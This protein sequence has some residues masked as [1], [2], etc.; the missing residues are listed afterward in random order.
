MTAQRETRED[1]AS[2]EVGVTDVAPGIARALVVFFLVL[3]FLVPSAQ[4]LVEW[5]RGGL[6]SLSGLSLWDP[7]GRL[8]RVNDAEPGAERRREWRRV[9]AG[10]QDEMKAYETG[11]EES[12]VLREPVIDGMRGVFTGLLGVGT[13]DAYMGRDGWLFYRPGID[14]LTGDPFL[15]EER[16]ARIAR[17][18]SEFKAPRAA[19]PVAAL[20]DFA[21]ALKARDIQLVVVPAPGKAQIYPEYF[22]GR[23]TAADAGL[24]N[25]SFGPFAAR[26]EEAGVVVVDLVAEF[27][28]MRAA[29]PEAALY[30]RTDTHWTPFG[31][32]LAANVV[33]G[34][35]L[36]GVSGFA[37][38]EFHSDVGRARLTYQGDVASMLQGAAGL[39]EHYLKTVHVEP[40]QNEA[41]SGD[42]DILVLDDSF[43]N[44]YS[45]PVM[46]WGENAGFVEHLALALCRPMDAITIN[47]N[48][49]H[50]ARVALE[51]D[52]QK[53]MDR[54]KGKRVVV[55]EFASRELSVGDWKPVDL[56]LGKA[57]VGGAA[58]AVSVAGTVAQVLPTPTPGTVP[59]TECLVGIHLE[60]V[61]ALG[62]PANAMSDC[63]VYSWGMRSN[64][65]VQAAFYKAG[66]R[67][68]LALT[69]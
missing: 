54:L 26:L 52:L 30:L 49:A 44:I 10:L 53:G 27:K 34:E 61:H 58:G 8:D 55:L 57:Q 9:N 46:G 5:K 13:E 69:P 37:R 14:H 28:A 21:S 4:L 18:G 47:D 20:L 40:V 50:A 15:S 68:E 23:Y 41:K 63:V 2:R 16:L 38:G 33:A 48:G 36:E 67:V 12:W 59:Y 11:L 25:E 62:D 1:Q 3:I 56:T 29:A 35:I 45:D 24:Y 32:R 51:R 66:D 39:D 60:G 6:E 19:D 65:L 42:S 31:M 7:E 22:S 64:T 43:S 17:S